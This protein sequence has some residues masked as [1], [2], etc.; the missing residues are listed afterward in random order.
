MAPLIKCENYA[1]CEGDVQSDAQW[2][3]REGR[4]TAVIRTGDLTPKRSTTGQIVNIKPF[5]EKYIDGQHAG[6]YL[7]LHKR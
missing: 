7:Q 1:K 6:P 5:N 2:N 3:R 4:R